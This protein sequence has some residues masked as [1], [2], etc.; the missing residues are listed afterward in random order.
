[1][2]P[3]GVVD[4]DDLSGRGDDGQASANGILSALPAG[5][6]GDR[7]S[8]AVLH[9]E[10]ARAILPPRWSHD[11]DPPGSALDHGANGTDDEG[12]AARLDEGLGRLSA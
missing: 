10:V 12:N 2:S 7:R 1:M 4:E 11:D 5:D 9:H 6:D 3:S 8:D